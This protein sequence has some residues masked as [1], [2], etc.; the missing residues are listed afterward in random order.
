[1]HWELSEEQEMFT[2]SLREW[3]AA[4]FPTETVRKLQSD[5]ETGRFTDELIKDGWWGVGYP[6][7]QSGEGGGVLELALAAREFGRSAAPDSRWLAAALVAP[8]LTERE[9]EEQLAGRRRFVAAIRADRHPA[10]APLVAYDSR[11]TGTVPHVLGAGDAD[12]FVVPV[13]GPAGPSLARVSALDVVVG[14]DDLLDRSR[15]AGAVEFANAPILEFVAAE[16][17]ALSRTAIRAAVLVAADALGSAERMLELAVEYSKQ[18][19][20][21]GRSIGSFQAVKHAAAQMLV[22][23]EASYSIALY[24]A[25]AVDAEL[26]QA[27]TIAAVAKAQV[28]D[29][30]SELAESA[31][32]VHGAI[33]YTWEH[34]L[35][36][37]YKR[38]KLDRTLY[39]PPSVWNERIAAALLD[40]SVTAR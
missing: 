31:L 3:I 7:E 34:D 37:F 10:W 25:A 28:S 35:H 33:G 30:V 32:T 19:Q 2:A 24:A 16:E 11:L 13:T 38:A 40:E 8:L 17:S 15:S 1:M 23:V 26:D 5:G 4:K 14:R 27:A 29:T 12:V 9:M 18:R 22:T 20:Q 39:G 36:L 21:F 6:E